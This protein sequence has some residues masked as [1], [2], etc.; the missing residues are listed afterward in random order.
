MD[1]SK[2]REGG[3]YFMA[4]GVRVQC[5]FN[6]YSFDA[7]S[8]IQSVCH[9]PVDLG[10]VQGPRKEVLSSVRRRWSPGSRYTEVPLP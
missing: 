7:V 4:E 1:R 9:S 2:I 8:P 6:V 5:L 3:T 10:R